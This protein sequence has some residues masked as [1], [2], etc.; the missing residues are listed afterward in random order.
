MAQFHVRHVDEKG[1]M[2]DE[3]MD[4][5]DRDAV[6]EALREKNVTIVSI[7]ESNKKKAKGLFADIHIPF[8]NNKVSAHDKIIFIR[9]LG[10]MIEA[11]LPLSRALTVIEKQTA[12]KHFREIVENINRHISQGKTLSEGL[13]EYLEIFGMLTISMVRAGEESGSLSQSL[14]IVA[15]QLESSYSLQRKIRGALMYPAIIVSAM[16]LIGFAMLT[17]VVPT[18]SKTFKDFNADLPIQTKIVVIASDFFAAHYI[19]IIGAV[20]ATIIAAYYGFKTKKGKRAKDYLMLR[21]PVIGYMTMEVNTARMA[22]TL[23]SLLGSGVDMVIATKITADVLQNSYYKEALAL[24][25]QKIQTG[26][27]IGAVFAAREDL[28][29]VFVSEMVTVGEET[30]QLSKMLQ[31]IAVY[32]ESDIDQKTKDMS[33]IIEPVLMVI[34][35]LAVGFFAISMISP[36]YSLSGSFNK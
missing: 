16:V 9:N 21:L 15:N 10:T 28:F 2:H 36:I 6:F 35:G 13:E 22:R 30:G 24:V 31:G 12:N 34:I 23:S 33:S 11:G 26:A 7:E 32:Y 1:V 14:R 3:D 8:F 17:F 19:I 4:G 25:T 5:I 29:P 20:F 18:L 27:Q